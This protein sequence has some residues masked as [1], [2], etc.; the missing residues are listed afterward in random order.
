MGY[1][2]SMIISNRRLG[3]VVFLLIA[4]LAGLVTVQAVLL[5]QA[6]QREAQTF[7][8]NVLSAMALTVQQLANGCNITIRLIIV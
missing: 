6:W 2:G 1:D 5:R 7:Q 8:R 4:A 3:A